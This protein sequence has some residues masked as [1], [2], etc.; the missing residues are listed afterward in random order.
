MRFM[1]RLLVFLI[2]VPVFAAPAKKLVRAPNKVKDSYIVVLKQSQRG[3]SAE[4]AADL[5]SRHHARTTFV[6]REAFPGFTARMTEKQAVAMLKDPRVA[7]VEE[8]GYGEF[9]TTQTLPSI[10]FDYYGL[11][12]IDQRQRGFNVYQYQATYN[13]CQTGAGVKV[14]VIDTG[15][16]SEHVE[17]YTGGQTRVTSGVNLYGDSY[18]EGTATNPCPS[19]SPNACNMS[20]FVDNSHGTA[21]ASIIGGNT[22]GVAKSATI[23]P[24]R[25]TGCFG[26]DPHHPDPLHPQISR[27][28]QALEIVVLDHQAGQPAVVNMS[29]TIGTYTYSDYQS[30]TSAINA[31]LNDGVPVVAAAGNF[32]GDAGQYMPGNIPGVIN[33]GGSDP[34]DARWTDVQTGNAS[35]WGNSIDLFAPAS[36]VISATMWGCDQNG[37]AVLDPVAIRQFATAGTSFSAAL[38]SGVVAQ[39]LQAN[40]TATPAQVESWLINNATAGALDPTNLGAA[41]RLLYTNCL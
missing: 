18:N 17:F 33:V 3:K 25:V 15:V 20:Y 30:M 26:E 6:F 7:S 40:P 37:N 1:V 8:D 32:G 11:D 34:W 5:A 19:F 2:V 12:R 10:S 14:Y 41:N 9:A 29:L 36:G 16:W 38:V 22:Y 27:I 13:Y 31:V 24:L 4:V 39:Y 23:V 21:V 28:L 35:N